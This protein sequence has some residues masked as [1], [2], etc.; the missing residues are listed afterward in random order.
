MTTAG[1]IGV[2]IGAVAL[3][4]ATGGIGSGVSGAMMTAAATTAGTIATNTGI[5]VG[6]NA[7]GDI[8]K[9]IKDTTKEVWDNTTSNDSLRSIAISAG[10]AGLAKWAFT[11]SGGNESL[12][13][14]GDAVYKPSEELIKNNPDLYGNY[15]GV[16]DV[17]ANNIGLAN[18]TNDINLVGKPIVPY[19]NNPFTL[20]FWEGFAKEG[21]FISKTANKLGGMNSMA[22]YIHDPWSSAVLIKNIP[23]ATQVSIIPAVFVQY[24][25]SYPG[26]CGVAIT[27]AY[28]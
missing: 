27:G 28:K 7:D 5:Q 16:I 18:V 15:N 2:A 24:C 14:G 12:K 6:M 17:N 11:T 8:F 23:L 9:K 26:A 3:S 10:I 22:T 20:N 4:I 25:G 13:S 1:Q 19:S 21:G